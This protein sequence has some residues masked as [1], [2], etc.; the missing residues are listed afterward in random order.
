V[1]SGQANGGV[2]L[3]L[4]VPVTYESI[5]RLVQ[6][7]EVVGVAVTLVAAIGVV[8]NVAAAWVI[9]GKPILQVDHVQEQPLSIQR[10]RG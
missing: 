3:V 5:R 8:V 7:P 4:G 10:G 1:L 6:P 2:L 9:P